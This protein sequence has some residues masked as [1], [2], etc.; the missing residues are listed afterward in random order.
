MEKNTH[1]KEIKPVMATPNVTNSAERIMGF[2][3]LAKIIM[4]LLL[5][6]GTEVNNEY[7]N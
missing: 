1:Q 2:F 4:K 3:S 6:N 5:Y 7:S